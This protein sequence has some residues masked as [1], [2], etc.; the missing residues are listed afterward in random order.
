MAVLPADRVY[1]DTA[2]GDAVPY[3]RTAGDVP[4]HGGQSARPSGMPEGAVPYISDTPAPTL[5]YNERP[6]C[7]GTKRSG[8]PCKAKAGADGFPYCEAHRAQA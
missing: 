5:A 3:G 8:E 4:Y 6:T 7:I 1:Q 2:G